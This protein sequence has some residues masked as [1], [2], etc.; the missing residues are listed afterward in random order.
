MIHNGLFKRDYEVLM[1]NLNS[2]PNALSM[3]KINEFVK[4][5]RYL[6]IHIYLL[7]ELRLN[8]PYFSF[9]TN[10]LN[11]LNIIN[12]NLLKIYNKIQLNN[13]N[14]LILA[15]NDFPKIEEFKCY[16]IEN[17][18]NFLKFPLINNNKIEILN[19]ILLIEIPKI[20]NH[21][22]G[23]FMHENTSKIHL[24]SNSKDISNV[25]L[26]ENLNEKL[27][28]NNNNNF[29][30]YYIL[31]IIIIIIIILLLILLYNNNIN[32]NEKYNNIIILNKINKFNIKFINQLF[33]IFKEINEKIIN[34]IKT[35]Q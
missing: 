23:I 5:I 10:D 6:M 12:N 19:N 25:I 29:N 24:K 32:I 28:N 16:L 15:S 31:F 26:N 22:S 27:I 8:M 3:R 7:N 34:Y 14:L 9:Q 11:Q 1:S 20:T 13:N 17:K 21:I 30:N 4:R 33:I 35:L 18:F 2:L